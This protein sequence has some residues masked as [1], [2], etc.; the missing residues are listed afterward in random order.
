MKLKKKSYEITR[1]NSKTDE[2]PV[3]IGNTPQ[4]HDVGIPRMRTSNIFTWAPI[5]GEKEKVVMDVKW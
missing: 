2:F 1:D 5:R 4:S 3:S